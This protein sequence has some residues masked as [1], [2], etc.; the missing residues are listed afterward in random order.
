MQLARSC[1][2]GAPVA[3]R[4]AKLVLHGLSKRPTFIQPTAIHALPV[5]ELVQDAHH[6][7]S[8]LYDVAD[9]VAA[10]AADTSKSSSGFLSPLTD[11][12][13]DVLKNI[14]DQ[15]DRLHV[16]Y[17]YGY[18]IIALTI[19]VKAVT[20]PLTK[21]QASSAAARV[22]DIDHC[23]AFGPCSTRHMTPTSLLVCVENVQQDCSTA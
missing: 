12:L 18:S 1:P 9:A 3:L 14:Q 7:L 17:S 6:H 15:L 21:K 10:A 2:V 22:Y 20:F 19:L 13:E 8:S 5:S 4:S 23:T 11:T 16:P